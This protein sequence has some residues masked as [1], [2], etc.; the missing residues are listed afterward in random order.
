MQTVDI[1][2]VAHMTKLEA[3]RLVIEEAYK[4]L[5]KADDHELRKLRKAMIG[6]HAEKLKAFQELGDDRYST[7]DGNG[8]MRDCSYYGNCIARLE[9]EMLYRMMTLD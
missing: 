6:K 7:P 3:G 2:E 9:Q 8:L 1:R 5:G 4:D